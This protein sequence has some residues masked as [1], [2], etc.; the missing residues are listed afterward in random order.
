MI[1]MLHTQRADGSVNEEERKPRRARTAGEAA[2]G[3]E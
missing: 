2:D 3:K 1:Q